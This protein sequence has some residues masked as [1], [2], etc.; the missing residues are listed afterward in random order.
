MDDLELSELVRRARAGEP[1]AYEQLIRRYSPG[2]LGYFVRNVGNRSDA[3][4]LV[5]ET[6][7]RV[8]RSLGRY[9]EHQ[10]F[11]AWLFRLAYNLVIDHRRKHRPVPLSS[12]WRDD[13]S[14]EVF[15]GDD[16]D[17][18]KAAEA[19]ED[20]DRLQQ[21]LADLSDQQRQAILLRY[22]GGVSY[23]EIARIMGCPLGTALA[24]VH[25]GVAR[26]R[27]LLKEGKN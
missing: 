17:P 10:R 27:D 26:L 8:V 18:G 6:F 4:D 15:F 5:Q 9:R 11:E 23:E 7:L 25:R 12:F 19:K 24:R 22:F 2:L 14:A 1:Q 3:E 13:D 21:G 16:N 20:N